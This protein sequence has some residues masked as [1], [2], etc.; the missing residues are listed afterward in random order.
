[1]WV[2]NKYSHE[3]INYINSRYN[4]NLK[5]NVDNITIKDKLFINNFQEF[6]WPDLNNNYYNEL[7]TCYAL[8][9]HI[10]ILVDGTI[11]PCCL[12]TQGTINLG[13]IYKDS[14]E[15]IMKNYRII[16]MIKNFKNNKKYE[17]LCKHCN[18][19]DKN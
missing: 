10:G 18:F 7:G 3:M 15:D 13:N 4:T 6:I 17:E 12:D 8:T 19:I 5:N 2:K 1:M 16:N 14:L 9:D 11:I